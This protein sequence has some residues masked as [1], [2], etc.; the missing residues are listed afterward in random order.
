MSIIHR[1][2]LV[3]GASSGIG[4]AIAER[5]LNLGHQVL[6]ISRDCSKFLVHHSNFQAIELDLDA[7]EQIRPV[8]RSILKSH[9]HLDGVIFAAGIGQFG[10]LEEFSD[11]QIE[12]LMRVNFTANVL[13]TKA[14]LPAFKKKPS[15]DLIYIGSEAALKGSRKGTLYCASKFALRGFTQALREECASHRIRITLINPGM[16]KTPFFD[17]LNFEP[18]PD[19]V[20]AINAR[21]L[22]D[23]VQYLLESNPN[24]IIDEITLNPMQKVIHFKK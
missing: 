2:F 21:D 11:A 22:A 19:Q 17:Q 10:S 9:P 7:T 24:I 5:L 14:L 8:I 23:T 12:R 6:G 16:V 4:R 1:C 15:T 18:G 20:H 13:L 3:T